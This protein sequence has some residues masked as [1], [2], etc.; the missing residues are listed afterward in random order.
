MCVIVSFLLVGGC[1]GK[2][3]SFPGFLFESIGAHN[4]QR[5]NQVKFNHFLKG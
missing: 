5:E 3:V 2:R 4:A 1:F